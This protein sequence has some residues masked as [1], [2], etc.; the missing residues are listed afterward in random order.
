MND[1]T[2]TH[3]TVIGGFAVVLDYDPT[4]CNYTDR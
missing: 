3:E 2:N 4:D 1:Y